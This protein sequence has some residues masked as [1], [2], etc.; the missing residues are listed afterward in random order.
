MDGKDF[1]VDMLILW[2]ES[3]AQLFDNKGFVAY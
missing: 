3:N 1:Q 2:S